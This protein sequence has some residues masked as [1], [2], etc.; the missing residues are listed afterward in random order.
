M[1]NDEKQIVDLYIPRTCSAT[2]KL[3]G[4]KEHA[5]VQFSV[6][7][8]DE[9]TGVM[10]STSHTVAISGSVRKNAISDAAITRLMKERGVLTFANRLEAK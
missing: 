9:E 10:K 3:I 6:C 1:Q 5:S 4:P 2:N 8:I 7:D